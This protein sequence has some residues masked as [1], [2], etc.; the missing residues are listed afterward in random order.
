MHLFKVHAPQSYFSIPLF[1]TAVFIWTLI[2]PVFTWGPLCRPL[3]RPPGCPLPSLLCLVE[4]HRQEA[5]TLAEKS[6][7]LGPFFLTCPCYSLTS[8]CYV[9]LVITLYSFFLFKKL[10]IYL[11]IYLWLCWVFIAACRLSLIAASGGYSSLWCAGFLWLLIAE[12]EL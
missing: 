3:R 11:F 5:R 4:K 2:S 12:H 7:H 6:I 8:A 10:F 9:C 1:L